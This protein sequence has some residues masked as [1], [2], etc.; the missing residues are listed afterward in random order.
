[1][2]TISKVRHHL[3][4]IFFVLFLL[5]FFVIRELKII[6]NLS[7]MGLFVL[8]IFSFVK[9]YKTISRKKALP[10]LFFTFPLVLHLLQA[11]YVCS[12]ENW[13]YYLDTLLLKASFFIL[14]F[15]FMVAHPIKKSYFFKVLSLFFMANVCYSMY[16]VVH[17]LLDFEHINQSYIHAKVIP[18][19]I[20]HIRYS[21]MLVTAIVSACYLLLEKFAWG[22][23]FEKTITLFLL[24]FLILFLHIFAVRSGL[25]SFYL[26]LL[27]FGTQYFVR[28]KQPKALIA[29]LFVIVCLPL[30][31]YYALPTF[32]ARC[33]N[34]M[35][36]LCSLQ[37]EQSAN[38]YSIAGR[39]ISYKVSYSLWQESPWYGVG[40]GNLLQKTK[41]RYRRDYPYVNQQMIKFPHNQ[42]LRYATSFGLLGLLVFVVGFYFPL[43]YQKNYQNQFLLMQY[44]LVTLS[45]FVEGTLETMHGLYFS[46]AFILLPLWSLKKEGLTPSYNL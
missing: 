40:V 11:G 5:G 36:D 9:N 4:L 32:K 20:N 27:V 41:A 24:S 23:R 1:M 16:V 37:T 22:F 26:L 13:S 38:Q 35:N 12:Q 18:A 29:M 19:P 33:R 39:L 43:F 31:S 14:P 21:L 28:R 7:L 25:L 44:L 2:L 46:L 10:W 6:S 34:T 8:G 3:V 15:V 17:Y 30:C 45:F 42:F